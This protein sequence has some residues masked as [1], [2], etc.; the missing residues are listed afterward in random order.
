MTEKVSAQVRKIHRTF[1]SPGEQAER[2]EKA[3]GLR[4]VREQARK[5]KRPG[6]RFYLRRERLNSQGYDSQGL[7]FGIGKPLFWFEDENRWEDQCGYLRAWNRE[8]AKEQIRAIEPKAR[9]FN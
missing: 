6:P 1:R 7:Y 4:N 9:F 3:A 2:D 8:E 5:A